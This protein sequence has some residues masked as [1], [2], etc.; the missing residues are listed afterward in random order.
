[1][2]QE[3]SVEGAIQARSQEQQW[4]PK[5]KNRTK[6]TNLEVLQATTRIAKAA[7]LKSFHLVPTAKKTNHPQNKC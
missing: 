1:M 7:T 4:W 6:T 2:R 3:G 5:K